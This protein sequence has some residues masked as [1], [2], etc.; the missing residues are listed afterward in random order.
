MALPPIRIYFRL[1]SISISQPG[2]T[3]EGAFLWTAFFKIDG[4][5]ASI[6]S[7]L[8]LQGTATVV[9]TPGNHGD[10]P[11]GLNSVSIPRSLGSW[12]TVLKPIP[13]PLSGVGPAGGVV[14]CVAVVLSQQDTPDD[15]IA[16]GHDAFNSSLQQQLDALIPQF[17]IGK[18]QVSQDDIN[19]IEG[20]VEN[21][22]VN[23]VKGALGIGHQILT[24][25]G[26]ENQ[27]SIIMA[28]P[29]TE[30]QSSLVNV[31]ATGMPLQANQSFSDP[32][33]PHPKSG[34]PPPHPTYNWA[35]DGTLYADPYPL[36]MARVLG[37]LGYNPP[38]SL[39]GAMSPYNTSSILAW[40][41]IAG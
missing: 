19:A 1:R 40:A 29:F 21:A 5:T 37:E 27:D 38:V 34:P 2:P 6:D 8:R 31:A 10:L 12:T 4:D 17:G 30:G 33:A 15:D 3:I 32:S 22:V 9:G 25:L 18:T 23:T 7:N 35:I 16:A 20:N 26:F 39:R 41:G 11:G 36:S 14:G 28:A 13:V 24:W